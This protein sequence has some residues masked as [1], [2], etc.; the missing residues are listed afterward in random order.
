[1]TA[2]SL[3]RK[4]LFDSFIDAPD[5]VLDEMLSCEGISGNFARNKKIEILSK[6]STEAEIDFDNPDCLSLVSRFVE[7][8][9]FPFKR[10]QLRNAFNHL[11]SWETSRREDLSTAEFGIK[12][13][14]NPYR[15]NACMVYKSCQAR[16]IQVSLDTTPQQMLFKA[17]LFDLPVGKIRSMINLG[18]ICVGRE[19]LLEIFD[20]VY[21]FKQ[22]EP[23]PPVPNPPVMQ[24]PVGYF[25]IERFLS[26]CPPREKQEFIMALMLK[27][28]LAVAHT[29][30][31]PE[32]LWRELEDGVPPTQLEFNINRK[33]FQ[34]EERFVSDFSGFYTKK[35]IDSII[36]LEHVAVKEQLGNPELIRGVAPWCIDEETYIDLAEVRSLESPDDA[37]T[38]VSRDSSVVLTR[39]ELEQH[40]KHYGLINPCT[41]KA[42]G[43]ASLKKLIDFGFDEVN[44]QISYHKS[45]ASGYHA[46]GSIE[47]WKKLRELIDVDVA[48]EDFEKSVTRI[49]IEFHE[50]ASP[51]TLNVKMVRGASVGAPVVCAK[52]L[53]EF[54][55]GFLDVE[56][57]IACISDAKS[58]ISDT[59]WWN[60]LQLTGV[61]MR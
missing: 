31:N 50:I 32:Q 38:F 58:L 36:A 25:T 7:P 30:V 17:K 33:F 51:E 42:I 35:E 19:K 48:S 14:E 43:V 24:S 52:T 47:E 60:T 44:D 27:Y 55:D 2:T 13:N 28:R 37:V 21:H 26:G 40:F 56:S 18:L 46:H 34:M 53:R 39:Q 8:R 45:R 11:M 9:F 15:L 54:L 49:L 6:V 5:C 57:D 23:V 59:I 22:L 41:G 1:M 3:S 12:T 4:T 10:G 61:G 16:G 29:P 20:S